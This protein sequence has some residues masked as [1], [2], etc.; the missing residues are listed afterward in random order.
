MLES[1]DS[2]GNEYFNKELRVFDYENM[3]PEITRSS[4][5]PVEPLKK[6]AAHYSKYLGK[7]PVVLHHDTTLTVPYID[8]CGIL[9]NGTIENSPWIIIT[10]GMSDIPQPLPDKLLNKKKEMSR[11]EI[12]WYVRKLEIWM[13]KRILMLAKLPFEY[14]SFYWHWH[15]MSNVFDEE[16][17][18]ELINIMFFPPYIINDEFDKDLIIEDDTVRFL[19]IVPITTKEMNW[20]LEHGVKA[21]KELI[22]SVENPL[23]FYDFNPNRGSLI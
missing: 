13:L 9:T 1:G 5:E 19:W 17:A 15:T 14:K 3:K 22:Q 8:I 21:W 2:S 11:I 18:G 6:R 7:E 23:I 10:S 16:E 12:L 20:K 4:I